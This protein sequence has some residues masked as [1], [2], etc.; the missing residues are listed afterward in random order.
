[1]RSSPQRARCE[2]RAS[3]VRCARTDVAVQREVREAAHGTRK[4]VVQARRE[5]STGCNRI[6]FSSRVILSTQHTYVSSV[7]VYFDCASKQ[8]ER[9]LKTNEIDMCRAPRAVWRAARRHTRHPTA[10]LA[11]RKSDN[12]ETTDKNSRNS[13]FVQAVCSMFESKRSAKKRID[14]NLMHNNRV[15]E[16]FHIDKRTRPLAPSDTSFDR[17]LR[18]TTRADRH[19]RASFYCYFFLRK[20][21]EPR[22]CWRRVPECPEESNNNTTANAHR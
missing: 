12:D 14:G 9:R 5:R 6:D 21:C 8:N 15:I 20:T 16:T 22:R 3:H 1:M 11:L 2:T 17:N 4:R 10:R 13:R 19:N 18:K 7:A